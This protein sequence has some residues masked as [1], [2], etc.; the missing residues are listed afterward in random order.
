MQS[1]HPLLWRADE[2]HTGERG[3]SDRG[4]HAAETRDRRD[5]RGAQAGRGIQPIAHRSPREGGDAEV[6]TEGIGDEGGQCR[7]PIGHG[8]AE[9]AQCQ[10]IIEAEQPV[11]Q[12][13]AQQRAE[14]RRGRNGAQMR[15]HAAEAK[16]HKLTAQ[17][18]R[19]GREDQQSNAGQQPASP[20]FAQALRGLHLWC[21]AH[22]GA[23]RLRACQ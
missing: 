8:F 21:R 16:F 12:R 19:D 3:Q 7:A 20:Q 17:P 5:V 15:E 14:Q 22:S 1:L 11:A 23:L 18:D 9:V 2:G 10:H 13:R 4:G 6:M